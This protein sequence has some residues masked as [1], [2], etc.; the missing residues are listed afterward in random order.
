MNNTSNRAK[1]FDECKLRLRI[2]A[3][4]SQSKKTSHQ[5]PVAG[6]IQTCLF[7]NSILQLLAWLE[8]SKFISRS[9]TSMALCWAMATRQSH[10]FYPGWSALN[11]VKVTINFQ[12]KCWS[13]LTGRCH[14]RR[15][16]CLPLTSVWANK[17]LGRSRSKLMSKCLRATWLDGG[18]FWDVGCLLWALVFCVCVWPETITAKWY[19]NGI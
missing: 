8:L 13:E 2:K 6:W 18:G 3:G 14:Y 5:L 12:V 16:T 9:W 1:S 17:S 11:L 15:D 19:L 4:L 7:I 10:S